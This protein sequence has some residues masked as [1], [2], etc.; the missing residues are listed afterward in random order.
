MAESEVGSGDEDTPH[1]NGQCKGQVD[2][3]LPHL[4][5]LYILL[6]SG[7]WS[8]QSESELLPPLYR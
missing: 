7:C 5:T 3:G 1:T 2:E 8:D 4:R 6:L